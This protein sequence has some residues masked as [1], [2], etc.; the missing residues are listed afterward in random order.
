MSFLDIF[1][2]KKIS[3]IIRACIIVFVLLIAESSLSLVETRFVN[4][5]A[6]Q[7]IDLSTMAIKLTEDL[8]TDIFTP[9]DTFTGYLTGYHVNCPTCGGSLSCKPDYNV[10]DGTD[11]YFDTTYGTVNIVA[12]SKN[13]PCGS[14]V[15]FDLNTISNEPIVAI[16]L[17]RGVLGNNLDLLTPTDE[18]ARKYVGRKSISYDVL[19]QGWDS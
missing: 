12:S 1:Q 14:I 17:D 7:T 19:R 15:K 4:L 8:K 2:K 11:T 6:N 18:Y 3:K 5:S 13:L 9:K 16:V 10:K